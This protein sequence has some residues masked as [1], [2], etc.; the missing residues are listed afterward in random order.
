[1]YVK[2][3][4]AESG[5]K[6]ALHTREILVLSKRQSNVFFSHKCYKNT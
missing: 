3:K 5:A 2:D 1:M 4:A 6:H